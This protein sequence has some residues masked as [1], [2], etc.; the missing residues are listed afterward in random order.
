M[1]II[2]TV[3]AAVT[4]ALVPPGHTV[5]ARWPR[6]PGGTQRA[7]GTVRV[8]SARGR[9]A[10]RW[11]CA[12]AGQQLGEL[13]TPRA[14]HLERACVHLLLRC[15]AGQ[16]Q[17]EKNLLSQADEWITLTW[18]QRLIGFGVSVVLER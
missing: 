8:C 7:R 17:Q 3:K 6:N 9:E 18:K 1:G 5:A 14:E 16:E 4:G 2:D 11:Q 10:Q 15:R 12:L 13:G